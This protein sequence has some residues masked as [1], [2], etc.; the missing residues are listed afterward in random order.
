MLPGLINIMKMIIYEHYM[1]DFHQLHIFTHTSAHFSRTILND[2]VSTRLLS[3]RKE[4]Q[5]KK[6][7]RKRKSN[8]R[9]DF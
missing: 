4:E 3:G 1:K 7:D 6:R 2:F 5:K 8:Y 9:K